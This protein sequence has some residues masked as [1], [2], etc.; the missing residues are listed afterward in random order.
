SAIGY[1]V[2]S[3]LHFPGGVTSPPPWPRP[4]T[5]ALDGPKLVGRAQKSYHPESALESSAA[6]AQPQ[7]SM[8]E[9]SRLKSGRLFQII[10]RRA[11]VNA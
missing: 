5:P 6:G 7:T 11:F 9:S 4:E 3:A 10:R 8:L 1:N 2:P